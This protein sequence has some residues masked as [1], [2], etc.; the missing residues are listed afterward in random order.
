MR[1]RDVPQRHQD[2]LR[3]VL[4]QIQELVVVEATLEV[5]EEKVMKER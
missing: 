4:E 1:F 3:E 2:E 5:A